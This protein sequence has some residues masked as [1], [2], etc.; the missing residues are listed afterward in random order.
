MQRSTLEAVGLKTEF[1]IPAGVLFSADFSP[2]RYGLREEDKSILKALRN[3]VSEFNR[4]IPLDDRKPVMG[5]KQ[6]VELMY[7]TL[8]G[9]DH[10]EVWMVL[11]SRVR[12]PLGRQMLGS[13]SLDASVID[14]R[15]VIKTALETNASC[16]ILYHN[17]PS[18]SPLPS[19]ADLVETDR[20]RKALAV[21]D[22]KLL[23]HII[24]SDSQFF[25]FME[26]KV[27]QL[28]A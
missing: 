21:F 25:S 26:E 6:A 5:T 17:H 28:R 3:F 13:G 24:L 14:S 16:V 1:D 4:E 9:L 27:T 7:P 15:R 23:D 19:R 18:G 10:E 12:L 2:E 20:L 22:I 8:R 11:L